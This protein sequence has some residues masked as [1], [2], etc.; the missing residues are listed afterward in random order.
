MTPSSSAQSKDAHEA[1]F[2]ALEHAAHLLPA[3]APIARFVHHNTLH[4]YEEQPFEEAVLEASRDLAAEPYLE[5][6]R[7][8]EALATGRIAPGDIEAALTEERTSTAPLAPGLP[9]LFDWRRARLLTPP[10]ALSGEAVSWW[11]T[12][13]D[14]L[15]RIRP[16]LAPEKRPHVEAPPQTNDAHRYLT[17]LWQACAKAAREQCSPRESRPHLRFRDSVLDVT[18]RDPDALVNGFAIRFLAGYLDQG[19]AYWP[20]P[21]RDGLYATFVRI[22]RRTVL[23]PWLDGLRSELDGPYDGVERALHELQLLGASPSDFGAFV[24]ATLQAL[25]GWAGMVHQF[26][27]RPDLTP[28]KAPPT[29]LVDYLALRL[30][31]DRVVGQNLARAAGAEVALRGGAASTKLDDPRAVALEL[32]V[33]SQLHGLSLAD[34]AAHGQLLARTVAEH[35]SPVRRA[36]YHLAYERHFRNQVLDVLAIQATARIPDPAAPIAQLVFCIDEREESYR[37]QLEELEPRINTYG[38]AGHFDVMMRFEGHGAPY[39]IPLCPPIVTPKHRVREVPAGE[40]GLARRRRLGA[41]NHR[42]RIAT[43]TL[44]R[45][46]LMSLAGL[47]SAL[48]LIARTLFPRAADRVASASRNVLAPEV[49]T[50]LELTRADDAPLGSDGL[51]D[52]FTFAEQAN[53]VESLLRGIGL[54]DKFSPLVV[55]LGHGSTSVNN[56]HASAYNCGACAGGKGGANA[57]AF[58]LM[59]N[60]LEVRKLLGERNID[61]PA[62]TSFVG[63]CHDTSTDGIE[64]YDVERLTTSARSTLDGLL[65][66]LD[67]AG[68]LDAHERCRRFSDVPLG[69]SPERALSLAIQRTVDL[70][71]PRPEYCHATNAVCVVG[72]RSLTRGLYLDR[73]AFLVSYD[74]TIDDDEAHLLERIL[75]AVGPVGAGINLEYYFSRVDQ[76][77]FGSGTKLPHNITGL[78]GVMDGHA[79]DLRTGLHWQTVE[80]HEPMRLLVVAEATTKTLGAI[81]ARH[82]VIRRLVQNRWILVASVDP[83][84]GEVMFLER[85]G[86][87]RHD[88]EGRAV[89]QATNSRSHYQNHREHLPMA[90]LARGIF[91]AAC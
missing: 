39:P 57:R 41:V 91:E 24:H 73:R 65:P 8:I 2:G 10:P 61:V 35:D 48:P 85:D 82:A 3:Q 25:P 72:R 90:Q 74:P 34:V 87:R 17:S 45:G 59:A 40:D 66:I 18:G 22:H 13:T 42:R 49:P 30:L 53:I 83:C 81:V 56:P 38:Y 60:A 28:G 64:W 62:T 52:G 29:T 21:D 67:R 36:T 9:S 77:R 55:I 32:F 4:A 88:P 15:Y 80:L 26:E 54:V 70:A 79:S 31:L 1:L 7:Y 47:A 20:M 86:F 75:G 76:D 5:E 33:L 14:A 51:Y 37:R 19:I 44:V 11:L 78:I 89:P 84:T 69:L 6:A 58:A 27:T 46:S 71:Q 16:A 50:Q 63:A 43:R 12:E 23:P 68:A